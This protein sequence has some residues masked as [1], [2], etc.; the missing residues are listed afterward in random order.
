MRCLLIWEQGESFGHIGPLSWL[1]AR[2]LERKVEVFLVVKDLS[3]L[4]RF[5]PLEHEHLHALQAPLWQATLANKKGTR[6]MADI[7]AQFGFLSVP[8][9]KAMTKSWRV[10]F[11]M[12]NPDK[13]VFDYAPT[14]LLAAKG[15][16]FQKIVLGTGFAEM[17]PGCPNQ[18]LEPWNSSPYDV[19]ECETKIVD[20]INA[21][22][23]GMQRS[24][25]RYLS[26]LFDVEHCILTTLPELDSQRNRQD[27][28]Y[29]GPLIPEV[30]ISSPW[31]TEKP[32]IVGYLKPHCA[33]F[34][35]ILKILNVLPLEIKLF[36]PNF[37]AATFCLPKGSVTI[38][39]NPLN[40][41]ELLPNAQWCI[42]HAGNGTVCHSLI[43]GTPLIM[44]PLQS[45]Q[46]ATAIKV[47]DLGAGFIL[48][49]SLFGKSVESWV[50][51]LNEYSFQTSASNFRN[52]YKGTLMPDK[53]IDI[54]VGDA[55]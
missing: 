47:R 25:I 30:G 40:F 35:T 54:I 18:D 49:R 4:T 23:T 3:I 45:E 37:H 5:F 48:T 7:L 16:N 46:M 27:G 52:R 42:C 34:E 2:L 53:I 12:I 28:T 38:Y 51:L 19:N 14:A 50:S 31:E 21:V 44:L 8:G 22:L 39:S 6:C 55:F 33:H 15:F 24:P 20:N 43:E 41:R 13:V 32:K 36:C 29:I 17:V 11:S 10:L 9:L 26:D 1:T